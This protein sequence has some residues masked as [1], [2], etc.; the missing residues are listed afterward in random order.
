MDRRL[1]STR[2]A[3]RH[4]PFLVIQGSEDAVVPAART[5]ESVAKMRELGMQHLY[6]EIPGGDH[7][8]VHLEEP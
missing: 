6:V 5:R 2:E 4:I 8:L 1:P 3:I 7:S